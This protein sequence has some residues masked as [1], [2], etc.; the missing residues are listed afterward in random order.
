[1]SVQ[2]V[3]GG[4]GG[5]GGGGLWG[6]YKYNVIWTVHLEPWFI[7]LTSLYV[8]FNAVSYR[9]TVDEFFVGRFIFYLSRPRHQSVNL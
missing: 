3:N 2:R 7:T 9:P 6:V 4:G 8:I 1:M 5:G